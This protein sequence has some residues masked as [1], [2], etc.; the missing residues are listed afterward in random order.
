[1]DQGKLREALFQAFLRMIPIVP[2]NEFKAV[3]DAIRKTESDIDKDVESAIDAIRKSSELVTALERKLTEGSTRLEKLKEEHKRL[4]EL[5]NITRE[6]TAAL[7]E[8]LRETIGTATRKERAVSLGINLF[9]GFVVSLVVF[10]LGA[11]FGPFLK[12]CL[13][14]LF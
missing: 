8:V 2:A 14:I 4:S 5:T 3:I 7:S 10:L 11:E 9:A 1:M 13:G 12:K 6:Q